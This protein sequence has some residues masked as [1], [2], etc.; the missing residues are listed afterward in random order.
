V[1]AGENDG[2]TLHHVAVARELRSL[3][4]PSGDV[5]TTAVPLKLLS[6][7]RKEKSQAL[8]FAQDQRG[9]VLGIAL[10]NIQ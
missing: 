7:Q 8:V 6:G 4:K 5:W 1:K 2:V 3:G 10:A 9:R